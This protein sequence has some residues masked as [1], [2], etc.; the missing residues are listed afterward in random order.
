MDGG[1]FFHKVGAIIINDNKVLMVKNENFPYFYPVGGRV[2]LGETSEDAVLRET[3]EE[4]G[5]ILEIDRLAFIHENYFVG[6]I[7]GAKDELFHEVAFYYLMKQSDEIKGIKCT[8][9]GADGGAESLHWLPLTELLNYDLFPDF[10]K[11]ELL[12]LKKEV[13]HFVTMKGHTVRGK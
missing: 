5:I 1:Y 6:S 10:Y 3:F 2:T 11:T 7:F 9:M 12:D 4:I 8:S 13:G